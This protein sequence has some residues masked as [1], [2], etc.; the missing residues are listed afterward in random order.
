M[1]KKLADTR[2]D[3]MTLRKVE[4]KQELREKIKT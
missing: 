4:F 1:E 2:S 3:P